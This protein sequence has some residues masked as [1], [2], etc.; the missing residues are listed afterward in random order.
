[1]RELRLLPLAPL[2][3]EPVP[4]LAKLRL[5]RGEVQHG[6]LERGPLTRRLLAEPSHFFE[7]L[8]EIALPFGKE[9]TRAVEHLRFHAVTLRHL[10]GAAS[11]RNA[12]HDLELGPERFLVERHRRVP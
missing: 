9:L 1:R 8:V 11:A 2:G 6:A 4:H 5:A 12:D 3:L 7:E 10:N